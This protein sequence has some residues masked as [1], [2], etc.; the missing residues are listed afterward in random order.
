[1][2]RWR[3]R[4]TPNTAARLTAA[5]LLVDMLSVDERFPD[6]CFMQDPAVVIGGQA[7]VGR[8]GA[9]SRR[10]EEEA[11]AEWLASRFPLRRLAP[12]ATL[13]G[14]D[15]LILAD[16]LAVGLSGRTN[17]QGIQQLTVALREGGKRAPF[18]QFPSATICTCSPRSPTSGRTPSW[19]WR[20]SRCR[21]SCAI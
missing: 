13:E 4:S 8:M 15:V 19:S 12:P 10:G 20:G 18:T 1:M 17:R 7:I 5:G 3:R 9:A 21:R 16:R 11:V 2:S 14:G 6:S